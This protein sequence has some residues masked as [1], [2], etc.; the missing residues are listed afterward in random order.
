MHKLRW[1]CGKNKKNNVRNKD[2]RTWLGVASIEARMRKCCLRWFEH[3]RRR[4]MNVPVKRREMIDIIAVSRGNSLKSWMQV[5]KKDMSVLG[6]DES[7]AVHR[8]EWRHRIWVFDT[9]FSYCGS[10]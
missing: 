2:I 10:I 3:V 9:T 1:M 5:I 6:L 8:D 4:P 7:V